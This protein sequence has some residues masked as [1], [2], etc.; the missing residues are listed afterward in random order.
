MDSYDAS[1]IPMLLSTI[2]ND[3]LMGFLNNMY[4]GIVIQSVLYRTSKFS[5]ILKNNLKI[6]YSV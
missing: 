1:S 3:S 4:N 2:F 6:K 5:M